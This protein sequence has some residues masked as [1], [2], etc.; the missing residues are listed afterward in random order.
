MRFLM[1]L[2]NLEYGEDITKEVA[3]VVR[4]VRSKIVARNL[5]GWK[6]FIEDVLIDTV[7]HMIATEF[8]Y[9]GGA[10]VAVGMQIAIDAAR[11]CSAQKRRGDYETVSIHSVDYFMKDDKDYIYSFR[12]DELVEGASEMLGKETAEQ[13][14]K[15][16]LGE[17]PK[18]SADVLAKCRTPEFVRWLKQL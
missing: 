8:Q 12:V 5:F 4:V 6:S 11:Y 9:S 17:I 14:R 3:S 2:M 13:V 16:L 15:F 10:Y 7:K 1:N 18:L